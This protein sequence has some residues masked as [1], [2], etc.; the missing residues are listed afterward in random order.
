MKNKR[1]VVVSDYVEYE[2][3]RTLGEID[4]AIRNKTYY[5]HFDGRSFRK[6]FRE[7]LSELLRDKP[8]YKRGR[9]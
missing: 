8:F 7:R 2:Q 9:K 6:T 1:P 3:C 4:R 5:K